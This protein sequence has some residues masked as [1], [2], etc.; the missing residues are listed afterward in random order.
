MRRATAVNRAIR[1]E[2]SHIPIYF[3]TRTP[4]LDTDSRWNI[5]AYTWDPVP[6]I[7]GEPGPHRSGQVGDALGYVSEVI[8]KLCRSIDVADLPTIVRGYN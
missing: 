4:G 6:G 8:G 5:D 3:L 1:M 2:G 7:G